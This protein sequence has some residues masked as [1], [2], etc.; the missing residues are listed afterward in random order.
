MPGREGADGTRPECG[1][2]M[3]RHP[4]AAIPQ[5]ISSKSHRLEALGATRDNRGNLC[6]PSYAL[7]TRAR[8]TGKLAMKTRVMCGIY[9]FMGTMVTLLCCGILVLHVAA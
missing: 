5:H 4:F 2:S 1:L 6:M 9:L 8:V 7:G 3:P